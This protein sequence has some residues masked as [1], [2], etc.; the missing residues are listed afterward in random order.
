MPWYTAVLL[1]VE[2]F[3]ASWQKSQGEASRLREVN[4]PAKALLVN[5]KTKTKTKEMKERKRGGGGGRKREGKR[6]KGA[7]GNNE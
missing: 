4:R 1:G 7:G 6:R 2:R 5:Q 3:M